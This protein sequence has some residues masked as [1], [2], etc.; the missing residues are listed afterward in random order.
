[1]SAADGDWASSLAPGCIYFALGCFLSAREALG[2]LKPVK[3][4]RLGPLKE[5]RSHMVEITSTA[6]TFVQVDCL[7][8]H[9]S[10]RTD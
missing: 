6:M 7:T 5:T 3:H 2:A 4:P 10:Q 9:S 1:M 8:E